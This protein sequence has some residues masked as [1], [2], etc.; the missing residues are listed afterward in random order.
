MSGNP[1]PVRIGVPDLVSPSYFPAIA[2][3]ELGLLREEGIE[4]AHELVFPVTDAARALRDGT[5]QFLAGAAHAPLYAFPDWHGAKLLCA[6]SQN[7]YWFLVVRADLAVAKGDLS[8]LQGLRLGAAPGPDLGLRLLLDEAG[9]DV[10]REQ[11]QIMPIPAANRP[12]V[13]FGVVAAE[14]LACGSVDGFWAN[15]MGAEVAVR[16]G[17]GTIVVDARRGD[18]PP[19]ASGYTFP[20]LAATEETLLRDLDTV[21]L[22]VRAVVR[23]QQILRAEPEK[24]TAVGERLFPDEEAALIAE[25]ISRDAPYYDPVITEEAVRSLNSFSQRAGLLEEDLPFET[26]VSPTVRPLWT[27]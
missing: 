12:T 23:A 18:G 10:E 16:R 5:I 24:A 14:A 8:R 15:G 19:A 1:E 25:L 7:M 3:A 2:A 9:V 11:I 21:E 17:T 20:A 22:V 27:V 4:L 13:S 26:V 6:L